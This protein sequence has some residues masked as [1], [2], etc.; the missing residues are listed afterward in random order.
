[1]S[2][3]ISYVKGNPNG[4]IVIQNGNNK[5]IKNTNELYSL[6]IKNRI[7]N[8]DICDLNKND[9]TFVI[10]QQNLRALDCMK[11]GNVGRA[12]NVANNVYPICYPQLVPLPFSDLGLL[13]DKFTKCFSNKT[14][15]Y[16]WTKT[17]KDS[18]LK[19][20][21][22]SRVI[23]KESGLD[24]SNFIDNPIFCGN[25]AN[26]I[27]DPA[28]RSPLGPGDIT[29][30]NNNNEIVFDESFLNLFGSDFLYILL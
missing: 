25:L 23:F 7:T 5:I 30:P 9:Q 1:M 6:G 10:E 3:K 27:I 22:S 18:E 29:F 15:K 14:K 21:L 11:D 24:A 19:P 17:S 13:E 16:A 28:G 8:T 20:L 12:P 2:I 4:Q 26:E